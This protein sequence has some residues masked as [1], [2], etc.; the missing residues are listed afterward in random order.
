[1]KQQALST[2]TI[3]FFVFFFVV[4]FVS[5]CLWF[6]FKVLYNCNQHRKINTNKDT[7]KFISVYFYNCF[8]K[9]GIIFCPLF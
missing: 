8:S 6:F 3:R 2:S 4:V 5:F 9:L 1:M 7:L